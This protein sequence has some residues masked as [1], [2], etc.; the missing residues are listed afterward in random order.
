MDCGSGNGIQANEKIDCGIAYANRTKR[1]RRINHLP[2]SSKIS[3][4]CSPNDGKERETN[5]HLLRQ[6]RI[7]GPENKLHPNGKTDTS[8]SHRKTAQWSFELEEHDIHYRPRTSVKGQILADFIVE[9]LEDNSLDTPM[10]DKEELSDLW[11]LLT[12]G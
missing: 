9:R 7:T 4:Q 1:E 8:F 2:S 10:E 5:A 3:D 11:I 6:P 12:D